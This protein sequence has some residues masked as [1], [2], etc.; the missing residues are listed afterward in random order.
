M[1]K[2]YSIYLE[3]KYESLK[4]I[5]DLL[6]KKFEYVSILATDCQG[7]SIKVSEKIVDI[8]DNFFQER[9]FVVRVFHNGL[10]SEYAF[11]N[12]DNV[13]EIVGK[14][15]SSVDVSDSL[16]KAIYAKAEENELY[17]EQEICKQFYKESKK[18]LPLE[19]LINKCKKIIDTSM[20][21]N[22]YI[23]SCTC[24]L[25]YLNVSKMFL[26]QK[27]CLKQS[28]SWANA[29]YFC[30]VNRNETTRFNLGSESGSTLQEVLE[31]LSM[32]I[33]NINNDATLLL[34][35]SHIVPG[36][37][38][39]ITSPEISGLIAHE[40]FGHGVEMDMFVKNRALGKD[41]L[42]KKVGSP[43]VE[44][45]DG[46]IPYDN[47]SSYFFDDEGTLAQDTLE[48]KDGILLTGIADAI[49]AK[50]L[51]IAPTGNGKRENYC[52]KAYSRMTNTYFKSG[53]STLEEMISSIENGYLIDGEISGMEDPK[54]WGIQC[55]ALIG[56]E[57]K[58]GKLTGNIVSPIVINGNVLDLLNSV[59]MVSK[60][61]KLYG[62]GMCGKGYKEW[63]KTSIGGPYMKVRAKLG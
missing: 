29:S 28:Y 56:K 57:I 53:T 14:I 52:H 41:Y 48:I 31:K 26:S 23:I 18:D 47:V 44:L 1:E 22:E 11:N 45:H 50:K 13:N 51:N 15:I 46:A 39:C 55:V 63:V 43:Y 34:D 4:Q 20:E 49:A 61:F 12:F 59:S 35:A 32:K 24:N 25:E 8:K 6:K 38:D 3:E 7:K 17:D 30:I 62:S 10:Y 21:E 54:H 40:A 16:Y 33:D 42:L 60:D 27:K 36:E 37:Y 2:K 5:I 19:T 9:G 58:N